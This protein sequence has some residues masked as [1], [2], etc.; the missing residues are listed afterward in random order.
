MKP[1]SFALHCEKCNRDPAPSAKAIKEWTDTDKKWANLRRHFPEAF[2]SK[3]SVK[4]ASR[5]GLSAYVVHPRFYL[6]K[7]SSTMK[8]KALCITDGCV[9]TCA[10]NALH[11]HFKKAHMNAAYAIH[12]LDIVAAPT[13]NNMEE[14]SG[15]EEENSAEAD[16]AEENGEKEDKVEDTGGEEVEMAEENVGVM[17][18]EGGGRQREY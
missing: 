14:S 18:E 17:E 16:S 4:L 12:G 11:R 8:L 1:G 6:G 13:T 3:T 7:T 10:F 2:A 5:D 9:H 15:D